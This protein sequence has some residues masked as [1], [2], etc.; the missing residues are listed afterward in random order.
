MRYVTHNG[1]VVIVMPQAM[2]ELGLTDGQQ[3]DAATFRRLM[4]WTL[5]MAKTELAIRKAQTGE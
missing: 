2:E 5:A 4:E 1:S 3:I